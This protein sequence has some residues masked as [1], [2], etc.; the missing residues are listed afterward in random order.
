MD[1]E[2]LIKEI[3]ELVYK[4]LKEDGMENSIEKNIKK[5]FLAP[6]TDEIKNKY[7]LFIESWGEIE[8]INEGTDS[9]DKYDYIICPNLTNNELIDISMG[10]EMSQNSSLIVEALLKG[11][12]VVCVEEGLEYSKYKDSANS[13]F[14]Q[15]FED[16][17]KTLED[18]GVEFIGLKDLNQVI[19]GDSE[20]SGTKVIS[21][22]KRVIT[23]SYM[24]Q[25]WNDGFRNIKLSKNSI[26]TPLSRDF[27]RKNNIRIIYY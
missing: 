16:Y 22:E 17:K 2:K 19:D 8:F 7:S 24:E 12:Q 20:K 25:L 13:S 21:V 5:V 1:M 14:Y 18:Y 15:L 11:K 10:K 3:T 9:I 26:I 23:E 27:I 4:K 6:K